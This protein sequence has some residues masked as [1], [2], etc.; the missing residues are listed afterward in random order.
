MTFLG[1]LLIDTALATDLHRS[2]LTLGVPHKLAVPL[3]NVPGGAGGLVDSPALPGPLP[4]TNLLHR[5]VALP[6]GLLHR[7]LLESYLTTLLEILLTRLLL[8]RL[9]VGDVGVVTLLHVLVFTLQD[10]ILGQSLHPLLLDDTQS[11]VSRPRGLAEVH[12]ARHGRLLPGE[13]RARTGARTD[14]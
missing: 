5:P 9:E 11:P 13:L 2:L 7:L 8:G 3:V 1:S 14:E 4:V 6:D 12:S 10:W